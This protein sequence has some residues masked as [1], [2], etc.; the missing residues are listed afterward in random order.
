MKKLSNYILLIILNIVTYLTYNENNYFFITKY[1]TTT[2][3]VDI[4]FGILFNYLYLKIYL[5]NYYYYV[6]NRNNIIIRLGKKKYNLYIIKKILLNTV[7]IV[8]LN[9]ISDL[10]LTQSINFIH[11]AINSLLILFSVIILPKKKTYTNEL[12]ITLAITT[13]IKVVLYKLLIIN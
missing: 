4:M 12:I 1:L 11:L 5:D 6:L 3:P 2:R 8:F 10:I 9:I 13:L 7:L